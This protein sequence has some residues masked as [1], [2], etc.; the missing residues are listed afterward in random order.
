MPTEI[1]FGNGHSIDAVP[2][3]EEVKRAVESNGFGRPLLTYDVLREKD[4]AGNPTEVHLNWNSVAYIQEPS[5][6]SPSRTR[7]GGR[8]LRA[9]LRDKQ[10]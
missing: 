5:P 1:V 6:K 3:V 9:G 2:T 8:P 4:D 10:F 7:S